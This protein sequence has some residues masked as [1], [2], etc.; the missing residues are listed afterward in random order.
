M[1]KNVCKTWGV[2]KKSKCC[3]L[4]SWN[5][6]LVFPSLNLRILHEKNNNNKNKGQKQ[7]T[8]RVGNQNVS[9]MAKPEKGSVHH[10]PNVFAVFV[11]RNSEPYQSES[12]FFLFFFFLC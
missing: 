5:K 8:K 3:F 1:C 9:G 10:S 6:R 7:Q 12:F 11:R 2:N 4:H